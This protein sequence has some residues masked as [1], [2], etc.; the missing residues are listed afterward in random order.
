MNDR[1]D[2]IGRLFE[3]A[4]AV[5][6]AERAALL[7]ASAEPDDITNEVRSLL[8]A[9]ETSDDFRSTRAR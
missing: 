2:R 4:L 1:W 9:H 8:A 7:S 5:S 6:A 3:E